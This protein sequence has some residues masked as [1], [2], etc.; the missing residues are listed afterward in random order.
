MAS[1]FHCRLCQ[2]VLQRFHREDIFH[3]AITSQNQA[4][5]NL[6][7]RVCSPRC[8]WIGSGRSVNQARMF[9]YFFDA[10]NRAAFWR[11]Y[12]LRVKPH[13]IATL[14][15]H[16]F[17]G[18]MK[19][20]DLVNRGLSFPKAALEIILPSTYTFLRVRRIDLLARSIRKNM[21]DSG[22]LLLKFRFE[23]F[24]SGVLG[25]GMTAHQRN[26]EAYHKKKKNISREK[27]G[28]DH[29]GIN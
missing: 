13:R 18:R 27:F 12:R 9:V 28:G 14:A 23:L 6:S 16:F 25:D 24:K 11:A 19:L 17:V 22:V 26:S 5:P 15:P 3:R 7:L 21:V 4:K 2:T 1:G 10:E 8:I 20:D 29:C